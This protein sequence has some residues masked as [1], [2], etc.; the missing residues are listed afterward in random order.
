MMIFGYFVNI[1][2]YV[3]ELSQSGQ[4]FRRPQKVVMRGFIKNK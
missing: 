2:A 1:K 4:V 3:T